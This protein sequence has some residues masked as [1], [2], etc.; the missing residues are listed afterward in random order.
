MGTLTP[1]S[2]DLRNF[3]L[4]DEPLLNKGSAF[5]EEERS[6]FGL[7]GLLPPT[8]ETIETQVARVRK[9]YGAKTT[10]L[11]RHIYLRALQDTNETLFYRFLAE[12]LTQLMPI[13]YTPVVG[14]GC[15]NFSEI[16]RRP[17][18]LFLSYPLRDK[19]EEML[20]SLDPDLKVEVIVV[21]DGERIL[22]L[23]DQGAGG[24]GIPIGKLSLY[25][26]CGGIAPE[27]TLPILLDVGTNNQERLDDPL[28]IGWR[29]KR[30][31][32]ADYEAFVD[33]F[34]Q[35][36]KRKWP[37][38]LLQ[39]E[40]FAQAHATMFLERY[41]D[42]LCTFNDDIQG[43]A[44]V[45]VGAALAAAKVA[46]TALRDQTVVV[47]GAGSAG[48]GIAEQM[49]RAAVDE[50]A[51]EAEARSRYFMVDR[52]GLVLDDMAGLYPFQQRLAHKADA[53]KDWVG[54]TP[55]RFTLQEVI[56]NAKPDMMVGVSGVPGIF[57][58]PV[59]KQMAQTTARPIIFPL[60]NPTSRCEALPSDVIDWTEGRAIVATGSPFAPVTY[61]GHTFPIAQSNNS[62]IFPG[63]GLG[64][65]AFAIPRVSDGMFMGAARALAELSP[66]LK[67]PAQSLLPPI[68]DIRKVSRHIAVEV[69]R[70][71][72]KEGLIAAIPE[73]KLA[74]VVEAAM[75]KPV[76]HPLVD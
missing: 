4:I 44:A 68:A 59:V 55:G 7:H 19:M 61:A 48:C 25:T 13:V 18:G 3:D 42:Q 66:A 23:G 35:A 51:D 15:Q 56:S 75:W 28:Y 26:A 62:Y 65:R 10:D 30:V 6:H 29:S 71:A 36:V 31:T 5:T 33:R 2:T 70:R 74:E 39:F 8:V 46:G 64:V 69:G 27:T 53:L 45:V 11:E 76:Y 67:D 17:R 22:G 32:G 21:T 16:Y 50:G 49:I 41:R 37:N 72:M 14:L 20:D 38:V 47:V 24:M 57:T 1:V 58:E 34:V 63:L 43:T 52:E 9:A 54:A 73:E 60:S 40:D 12:D